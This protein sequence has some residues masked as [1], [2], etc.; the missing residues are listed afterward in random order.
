LPHT[1]RFVARVESLIDHP[2]DVTRTERIG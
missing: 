1:V 2:F